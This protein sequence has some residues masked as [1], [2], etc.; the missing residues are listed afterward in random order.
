MCTPQEAHLPTTWVMAGARLKGVAGFI[1]GHGFQHNLKSL[2]QI[3]KSRMSRPV[4][5]RFPTSSPA[6]SCATSLPTSRCPVFAR[7]EGS[8]ALRRAPRSGV[9]P[10]GA[11][12][13]QTFVA[14]CQALR[15]KAASVRETSLMPQTGLRVSGENP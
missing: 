8:C 6:L 7:A 3:P 12:L 13:D 4:W 11:S 1:E 5:A 15:K 9:W 2:N 10:R 14:E